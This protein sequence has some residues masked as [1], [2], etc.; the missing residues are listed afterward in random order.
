LIIPSVRRHSLCLKTASET[1][2]LRLLEACICE[3]REDESPSQHHLIGICHSLLVFVSAMPSSHHGARV[4]RG[5]ARQGVARQGATPRPAKVDVR[6][7]PVSRYVQ[8]I[9]RYVAKINRPTF[10]HDA[11]PSK[12]QAASKIVKIKRGL[13][14]ISL[15]SHEEVAKPSVSLLGPKRTGVNRRARKHGKGILRVL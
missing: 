9:L 11:R 15:A 3:L 7:H 8:Q 1:R 10:G 2:G 13:H 6:T 4:I 14:A 12:A 5:V